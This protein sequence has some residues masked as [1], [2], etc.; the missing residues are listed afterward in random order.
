M[1]LLTAHYSIHTQKP[2]GDFYDI[3]GQG[4]HPLDKNHAPGSSEDHDVT[5]T[6]RARWHQPRSVIREAVGLAVH[7][8]VIPRQ[9]RGLHRRALDL[10]RSDEESLDEETEPNRQDRH[11]GKPPQGAR[12]GLN[13]AAHRSSGS[14][15]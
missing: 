10:E 11:P 13:S 8:Q 6:G 15:E 12:A 7:D 3:A 14:G 5:E 2:S 4:D 1:P 9:Q